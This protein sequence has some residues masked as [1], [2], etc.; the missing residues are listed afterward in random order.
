[1]WELT[2]TQGPSNNLTNAIQT[3]VKYSFPAPHEV[4]GLSEIS[5]NELAASE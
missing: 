4:S 1:M 5:L 3:E 2:H